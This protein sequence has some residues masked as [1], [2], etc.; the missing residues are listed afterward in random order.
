MLDKIRTPL[1]SLAIIIVLVFSAVS[2]KNVYADDDK[3][4][5]VTATQV[6]EEPQ[7]EGGGK[8][9]ATD[10]AQDPPPWMRLQLRNQSWSRNRPVEVTP[11]AEVCCHH[12]TRP[13]S[14]A[15]RAGYTGSGRDCANRSGTGDATF[16]RGC[17][18]E[19]PPI[20][21]SDVPDNTDVTVLDANGNAQPLA[22]QAA[23]DAIATSDPIWCP[24]SQ[25]PTPGQ[26]GC[27]QSFSS[28]DAL[29]TFMSGNSTYQGAGTIYVEQ[30]AY[31]GNDPNHVIDFNS[32]NYNLSNI[33]NSDLRITGGWNTSNNTI[34]STTPSTFTNYT[35]HIGSSANPWGGSITIANISVSESP[36][37]GIELYTDADSD[38]NITNSSFTRNEHTGALIR[39]GRNVNIANST[40]GNPDSDTTRKQN[41]GLDVVS[42]A[43]TSLFAVIANNLR[44]AGTT[45]Q[46][47][48]PV[49]IGSSTFNGSMEQMLDGDLNLVFHGYGLQVV[50]TGTTSDIALANVTANNNFLWGAKLDAGGNIAI[51]DSEFNNNT[52]NVPVFID[53]TGLFITGGNEVA[54]TNVT[55]NG[56]RLYGAQ[57]NVDGTVSIN[58]SNFSDN[59]GVTTIS[60]VTTDHGHGLQVTTLSDIFI[61]NTTATNNTLFGAQ[62]TAGGQVAISNSTFSNTS[63]DPTSTAVVGKGLEIT[64]TGNASLAN[65]VLDNNQTTGADIQ[66]GGDVFL[67]LVTA[68]NNGTDGVV[69]EATCAHLNGGT[70]SGNGQYGLNLGTTSLDLV[71]PPVFSSN[72]AGDI[73][74]VAP[75]SCA[76]PVSNPPPPTNEPPPAGNVP[77]VVNPALPSANNNTGSSNLF[78]GNLTSSATNS[79]MASGKMSL[80]DFLANTKTGTSSNG[81]FIGM[82]TY[83]ETLDGLQIFVFYPESLQVAMVAP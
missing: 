46:A 23:A 83:V 13:G 59:R 5:E 79:G 37:N 65:V 28:F 71:S 48:G 19:G 63:T 82:Y 53:D 34:N 16:S 66:S 74:P 21:L 2:P 40:F 22:T 64:S 55:A 73:S 25:A 36:T 15:N 56:N 3:P 29:L 24:G 14:R 76:P 60:G 45:I 33:R 47:G 1:L 17:S 52:T 31:Q 69:V 50:T 43:E 68:T 62:L 41:V 54:L 27:T 11:S 49:T 20:I 77:P 51:S 18:C 44:E 58:D 39:A 70:Y 4:P 57:I 81:L 78:A 30:G 9:V 26:N 61:N 80:N 67:D 8:T 72:G 10:A 12:G 75:V 32:S 38:V 35:I 6:T 7:S 42:G